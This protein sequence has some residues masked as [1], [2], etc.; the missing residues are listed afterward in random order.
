MQPFF[1][2]R[3]AALIVGSTCL[4]FA[5][6]CSAAVT[7]LTPQQCERMQQQKTLSANNPIPC[8]RLAQVSFA[9]VDFNGKHHEDGLVVVLDV[10]APQVQAIFN[11]L[12]TRGFP[13][14][15]AQPME[16][17][18]GDDQAAMQAN[19]TSAF[20]GRPVTGGDAW[21]K[22]A[23]GVAIDINPRQNPYLSDIGGPH[24]TL[25]PATSAGYVTRSPLQPGMAESVRDVFFRHGFLVW[26]GSWHEPIDYQHFEIGSRTLIS[27]LLSLPLASARR[28]FQSY[29]DTY[30]SC[31]H[32]NP[33]SSIRDDSCARQSRR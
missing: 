28:L 18:D 14:Q 22:H 6:L 3:R 27:Q 20:N 12:L 23:Y 10:V 1:R 25:L 31:L 19:N 32:D 17:Y 4:F 16:S 30:I 7:P 13:L 2:H 29:I 9:Y 24:A 5:N 33:N 15:Q 26:G 21:S 8:T 11:T